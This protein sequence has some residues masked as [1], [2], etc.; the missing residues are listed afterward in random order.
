MG[1]LTGYCIAPLLACWLLQGAGILP[2]APPPRDASALAKGTAALRGKVVTADTGRPIRRAQV[3]LTGTEGGEPRT[4]ST[5]A[6]GVFEA[7]D[8][9]AGRYTV[10]VTKSGYLRLQYGQRRPGEP[11]RPIELADSQKIQNLDISLPKAS[12]IIGRVTDELG[13]AMPNAS[14]FPMQWRYFRGERRLVPVSGGGPF[15]RTDDTGQFRI[16]GLEPGD[17]YVMAVTRESWTDE[18][19]P[20]E[21][22][23]FLPTYSGSTAT[24]GDAA[25]VRVVLGQD[26][27][28]P[29]IAMVPGRVG[30]IS[31]TALSS[32]GVPLAGEQ[33]NLMQE[34]QGPGA[35]SSFGAPGTKVSADGSFTIRNVVPGTYK[36]TLRTTADPDRPAEFAATTIQFTGDDLTG[37]QIMAAPGATLRGRVVTES[38]E[39][40]ARDQK[41]T[42]AARPLD[43]SRSASQF[44]QDNGRMREDGTFEITGVQGQIRIAATGIPAGWYLRSVVHEGKDLVDTPLDVRGGALVDGVTVLLTR[45]L[46]EVRGTVLDAKGQV[47]DGSVILFPDDPAHWAEESRLIKRIRPDSAGAFVFRQVIPGTYLAA[48]VEYVRDGEF[49]DPAFL[50][51]LREQASRV[52]VDE[53][54]S[55]AP[56]TLTLRK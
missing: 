40:L 26:A 14:I 25:R 12:A 43:P 23:G 22:I 1:S 37:I 38:G 55:P 10:T 50:E 27:P 30:T 6:L 35:S 52:R 34:F 3:S 51:G 32:A 7:T 5:N 41:L 13:D 47:P 24:P 42:I 20:K 19:N 56:L 33:L 49:Q 16:T 21:R 48:A 8:L 44:S 39:A 29:D 45:T 2:G 28:I 53:G 9:P 54:G 31:G 46:P 18:K 4:V 11:G 17:Y 15:N 36:L